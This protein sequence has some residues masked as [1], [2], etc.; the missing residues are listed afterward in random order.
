MATSFVMMN[1]NTCHWL[2]DT[3]DILLLCLRVSNIDDLRGDE[4][5]NP[6][7]MGYHHQHCIEFVGTISVGYLNGS[8]PSK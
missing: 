7:W 3:S 4:R 5:G 8:R 6:K 1:Q 2:L